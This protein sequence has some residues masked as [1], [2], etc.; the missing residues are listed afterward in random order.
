MVRILEL[1]TIA[2]IL[3]GGCST[4]GTDSESHFLCKQDADCANAA[5]RPFCVESRCAASRAA[6]ADASD[7]L[8]RDASATARGS[9]LDASTLLEASLP[10]PLEDLCFNL[11][12]A[13]PLTLLDPELVAEAGGWTIENATVVQGGNGFELSVRRLT[14][15]GYDS[16]AVYMDRAGGCVRPMSTDWPPGTWCGTGQPAAAAGTLADVGGCGSEGFSGPNVVFRNGYVVLGDHS[17][18][19]HTDPFSLWVD[20]I[21]VASDGAIFLAMVLGSGRQ[22]PEPDTLTELWIHGD[23]ATSP[24]TRSNAGSALVAVDAVDAASFH[25]VALLFRDV[26]DGGSGASRVELQDHAFGTVGT[27]GAPPG[28]KLTGLSAHGSGIALM[29]ETTTAGQ[30]RGWFGVLEVPT[31][32]LR[33]DGVPNASLGL[34]F[35]V[36]LT[37]SGR[38]VAGAID[39]AQALRVLAYDA[40][41]TSAAI[42]GTYPPS[43]A[44]TFNPYPISIGIAP[45]GTLLFATSNHIAVGPVV[46]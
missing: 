11:P 29:G 42:L 43:D 31:L 24:T 9:R 23:T 14:P 17:V 25:G 16:R 19:G 41:G 35:G 10:P 12:A 44:G 3:A 1:L 13:A 30:R 18:P 2:V 7:A 8:S 46:P 22:P 34:P 39:D 4:N 6:G 5:G 15:T 20:R 37:E 36:A 26:T 33:W 27:W 28:V 38:L 40:K 45:D 21:S 32:A